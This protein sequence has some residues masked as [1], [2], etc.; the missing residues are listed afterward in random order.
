MKLLTRSAFFLTPTISLSQ[1]LLVAEPNVPD[2]L[3]SANDALKVA[4][5]DRLGGSPTEIA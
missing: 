2:A 3:I 4:I 1:H 5:Q